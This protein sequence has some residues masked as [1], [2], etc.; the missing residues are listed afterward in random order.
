MLEDYI[1]SEQER[2]IKIDSLVNYDNDFDNYLTE[3][4]PAVTP[5]VVSE[6]RGNKLLRLFRLHTIS[7]GN[8]ANRQFKISIKYFRLGD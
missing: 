4:Q 3:Y 8:A 5:W 7:D 2:G 6:L 1:D